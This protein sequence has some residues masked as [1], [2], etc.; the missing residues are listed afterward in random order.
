MAFFWSS[1]GAFMDR[2]PTTYTRA[3]AAHIVLKDRARSDVV[4]C[5]FQL[6]GLSYSAG[7]ADIHT[8]PLQRFFGKEEMQT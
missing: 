6:L 3:W 4:L 8:H 7:A 1:M 5:F 2:L